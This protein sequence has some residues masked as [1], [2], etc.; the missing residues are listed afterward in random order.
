MAHADFSDYRTGVAALR[1]RFD[2]VLF[3]V[4]GAR[5]CDMALRVERA[6]FALEL[7]MADADDVAVSEPP[8]SHP[9]NGRRLDP[10]R[11]RE[12]GAELKR[13]DRELVG[14]GC[15]LG[16]HRPRCT[17]RRTAFTRVGSAKKQLLKLRSALDDGIYR[18]FPED[19][20]GV[21]FGDKR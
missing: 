12:I 11:H 21:Y 13:I 7:A 2:W 17:A 4:R 20:R 10:A 8:Y 18:D 6:L 14:L 5:L 19:A 9:T 1:A 15:D 3:A 16:N